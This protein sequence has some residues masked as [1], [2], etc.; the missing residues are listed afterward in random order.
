MASFVKGQC[1]WSLISCVLKVFFFLWTSSVFLLLSFLCLQHFKMFFCFFFHCWG[2][3]NTFPLWPSLFQT[4]WFTQ[5]M[6]HFTT[7]AAQ[8]LLAHLSSSHLQCSAVLML[9]STFLSFS[10]MFIIFTHLFS[11]QK[12]L[13]KH[14]SD[15]SIHPYPLVTGT[16]CSLLHCVCVCIYIH[17]YTHIAC[18]CM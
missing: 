11:S 3:L 10:W 12:H 13:D 2:L 9:R 4:R 7:L 16:E 1:C 18:E 15:N 17:T 8:R 5:T 6:H 14:T